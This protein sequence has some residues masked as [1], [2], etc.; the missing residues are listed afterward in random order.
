MEY[1]KR[2]PLLPRLGVH[3][4]VGFGTSIAC[5]VLFVLIEDVLENAVLVRFDN[6]LANALHTSATD[7]GINLFVFISLFGGPIALALT[8][9]IALLLL[10]RKQYFY[11]LVWLVGV[12]GGQLLNLLLK[13]LF[14]RA[15]PVFSDPFAHAVDFSFPSGHTMTAFITYGL[16]AYFLVRLIDNYRARILIVF[17]AALMIVL[18]GISRIYLGVH[19]FSDVVAG[20]MVGGV[21]LGTCI[22]L[23]TWL[24]KRFGEPRQTPAPVDT[25]GDSE[26][27]RG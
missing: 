5:L 3:L 9:I 8:M 7:Y 15:R 22:R 2:I 1:L 27:T 16:L 11:V 12:S 24:Y 18:I 13:Q 26:G 17:T 10:L 19:Y 6:E 23:G 4:L 14:H 20:F 25:K 21:W